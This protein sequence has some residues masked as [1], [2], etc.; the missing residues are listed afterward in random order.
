[1]TTRHDLLQ[2]LKKCVGVLKYLRLQ[3]PASDASLDAMVAE[4]E[5]DVKKAEEDMPCG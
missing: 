3:C 1:M 4:I 2:L 5:Q